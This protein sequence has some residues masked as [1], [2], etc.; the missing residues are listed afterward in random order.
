MATPFERMKVAWES[1]DRKGELNRVVET[2]AAEGV[3]R[4]DLDAALGLLLDEARAAGVDDETE[5]IINEVGDRLHGWCLAKYHIT[6][7][8]RTAPPTTANGA[9]NIPSPA[10]TENV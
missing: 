3:T 8:A 9:T 10:P 4:E 2:M 5:E 7:Q 1:S 6:T